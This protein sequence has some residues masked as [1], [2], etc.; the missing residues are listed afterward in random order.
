MSLAGR[1]VFTIVA[2]IRHEA[3]VGGGSNQNWENRPVA[4]IDA[5]FIVAQK[6]PRLTSSAL[7][8]QIVLQTAGD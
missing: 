7:S 6:L 3:E 2:E 8:L 4:R 1:L 5:Q